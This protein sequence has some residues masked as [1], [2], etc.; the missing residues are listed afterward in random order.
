MTATLLIVG[1]G[2]ML[3][4]FHALD[5]DH[6]MAVSSLSNKKPGLGRMLRFCSNWALGHGG[7]LLISGVLLFGV[8][9]H[10]PESLQRAAELSVGVILIA[11]GLMCFWQ[12]KRQKLSLKQHS[13]DDVTHTHWHVEGDA[14]DEG[15]GNSA[16]GDGHAP[17]MVGVV[18]GLAGSAPALAL[19]PAA[20]QGSISVALGYLLV[21]SVGVLLSMFL[22]GLGLA[23]FQ[24][25]LQRRS[26]TVF[27]MQRYFI[28]TASI[29][30]GGVWF[31]QAL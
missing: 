28:A 31:V 7:V 25:F 17:M 27:Q 10:L 6:V 4:F 16:R 23:S 15:H 21:F 8:G 12:F 19:V 14:T 11:I 24:S 13:H 9:L 20:S 2:F 18:H 29:V 26:E 30:F 1:T 22:F 5:A 3:G